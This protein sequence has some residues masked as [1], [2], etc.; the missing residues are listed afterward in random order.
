MPPDRLIFN[1]IS[2]LDLSRQHYYKYENNNGMGR[3]D[4]RQIQNAFP[5]AASLAH[6]DG[7]LI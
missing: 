3:W 2:I 4:G 1:N 5:V 7:D 6:Y